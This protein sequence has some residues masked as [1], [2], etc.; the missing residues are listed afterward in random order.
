MGSRKKID[1]ICDD[2]KNINDSN[3]VEMKL[4]RFFFKILFI[5]CFLKNN[6]LKPCS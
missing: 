2:D 4:C 6:M 3:G 1:K 5:F